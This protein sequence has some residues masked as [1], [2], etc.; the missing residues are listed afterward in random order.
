VIGPPV[1][2]CKSLVRVLCFRFAFHESHA[3]E[4]AGLVSPPVSKNKKSCRRLFCH[5]H[6]PRVFLDFNRL[7]DGPRV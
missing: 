6:L 4:Q 5:Y 7:G 2:P 3:Y 1:E